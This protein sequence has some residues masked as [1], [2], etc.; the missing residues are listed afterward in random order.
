MDIAKRLLPALLLGCFLLLSLLSMRRHTLTYDE[1]GHYQ[2]GLQLLNGAA[3][4]FD[5]SKM[6]VSALNAQPGWL[7][8][9]LHE[10]ALRA[11]LERVE[12]GRLA[13]ILFSI[14]IAWAVYRWSHS[15]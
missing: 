1:P 10:G 9:R 13:T 8:S 6:P 4:R 14:L 15:L 5:N 12:T 7:A 2:Y 11:R 3:K